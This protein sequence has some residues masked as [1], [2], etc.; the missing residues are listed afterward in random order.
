MVPVQ[1]E[2]IQEEVPVAQAVALEE[3]VPVEAV[4]VHLR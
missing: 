4:V 3:E 2:E 1:V